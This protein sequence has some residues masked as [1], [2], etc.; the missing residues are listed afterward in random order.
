MV[1]NLDVLPTICDLAGA[2]I[3]AAVQGTSLRPLLDGTAR[4]LHGELYSE[5]T[6]HAAY[7]PMRAV[8]TRRHKYIRTW[9][10][11]PHWF[12]PNTD[13]SLSKRSLA[14]DPR[15]TVR[16]AREQLYDLV[17]D[18]WEQRDVA[19]E[20]AQ[21]DIL[22]E[23][24]ARVETTMAETGDPLVEGVVAPPPGAQLVP[25]TNWNPVFYPDR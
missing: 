7:D 1:S 12:G 10:Y 25:P 3:P 19:G 13:D 21:A 18:P 9:E 17:A 16:R 15:F 2:S 5:L 11:R 8:R 22:A 14:D 24:R 4:E 6:H 20:A 23:L